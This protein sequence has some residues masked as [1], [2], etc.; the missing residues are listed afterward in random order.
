MANGVSILIRSWSPNRYLPRMSPTRTT[1]FPENSQT[2]ASEPPDMRHL[3]VNLGCPHL[4]MAHNKTA[5][6]I[7]LQPDLSG[8]KRRR[9]TD[10]VLWATIVLPTARDGE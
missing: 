1:P 5:K 7:I 3:P 2:V 10:W 9:F 6:A 8:C 4:V